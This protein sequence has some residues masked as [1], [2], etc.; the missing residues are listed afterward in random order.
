L[1]KIEQRVEGLEAQA[2][3]TT[4]D[5]DQEFLDYDYDGDGTLTRFKLPPAASD[6]WRRLKLLA[7]GKHEAPV[8]HG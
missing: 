4:P 6:F 7:Y 3:T 5:Q 8:D 2:G 1:E